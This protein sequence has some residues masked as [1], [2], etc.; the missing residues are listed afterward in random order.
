MTS[1]S[2][3]ANGH[4]DVDAQVAVV[5]EHVGYG[6]VEDQAVAVHYGRVDALVDGPG[7]RLPSQPPPRPVQL[8]PSIWGILYSINH[9]QKNFRGVWHN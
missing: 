6:G 7:R 9:L 3:V 8:Q 4:C 1:H 5:G 2:G